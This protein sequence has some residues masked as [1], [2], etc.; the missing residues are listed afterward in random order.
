MRILV[1]QSSEYD[2]FRDDVGFVCSMWP[3]ASLTA[4]VDEQ[5]ASDVRTWLRKHELLVY[6]RSAKA[7]PAIPIET[8][9]RIRGRK[10][11][12]CVL[13]FNDRFGVLFWRFRL[14]PL[15][16]S[17]PRVMAINVQ[18]RVTYYGRLWWCLS[19][20]FDCTVLRLARAPLKALQEVQGHAFIGLLTLVAIVAAGLRN[21]GLHPLTR[22]RFL[23]TGR[24]SPSLFIFIPTL[25]MGGAQK[26][27]INFLRHVDQGKYDVEVCTLDAPDKF[28]EPQV[29][30]LGVQLTYLAC[31]YGSA[32]WRVIWA[33]TS[34]LIRKSPDAA[35]GWLPWATV[36]TALAASIAGVP[37]IVLSLHSQSP[38]R[39]PQPVPWWQRPLDVLAGRIVD[40]VIAC[41]N[42]CK[43]DY[44][45]WGHIPASKIF[46]V[47][48]GIDESELCQVSKEQISE[49]KVELGIVCQHVVGIVGRLSPEKDHQTFLEAV[50]IVREV[51]PLRAIVLGGGPEETRLEA[52]AQQMGLLESVLFLGRRTD[53]LAVIAA[54]DILVLTSRTEGFPVVLLEAQALGIPVVTTDAGGAR[55]LVEDGYTGYVVPCGDSHR[56]AE[57]IVELLKN[58]PRRREFGARAS[59]WTLSRFRSERMA[60]E[61]LQLCR[62]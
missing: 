60:A 50:R 22:R 44:R 47:Y 4:L 31:E 19:T 54:L 11:D 35:I 13:S 43:E 33:L 49:V 16:I 6:S 20:L 21:A 48:N 52:L 5:V 10:F 46:T 29:R 9:K 37:R 45:V 12:L 25:G 55:E 56:L 24:S 59:R 53:S 15:Q 2:R 8:M 62:I 57:R 18:K 32:Y 42:A 36:F 23:Q 51:L 40:A 7:R 58:E 14:L 26:A 39:L 30:Q 27:L 3:E 17:I 61:I 41:S 34:R 28:F 1:I 38:S